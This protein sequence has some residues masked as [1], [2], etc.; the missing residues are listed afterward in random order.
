MFK[1]KPFFFLE[2]SLIKLSDDKTVIFG[3]II[4]EL[5]Q[6]F[7]FLFFSLNIVSEFSEKLNSVE[8]EFQSIINYV[9]EISVE[10]STN[11]DRG[12]KESWVRSV[13]M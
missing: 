10:T 13:K 1:P 11:F 2:L 4:Y 3:I 5:S 12:F 9:V 8:P 7:F 6:V